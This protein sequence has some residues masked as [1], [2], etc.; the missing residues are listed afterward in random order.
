MTRDPIFL[1]TRE[2]IAYDPLA[3]QNALS[4]GD[5]VHTAP[6]GFGAGICG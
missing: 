5:L 6:E 1:R 4:I 3:P 2:G